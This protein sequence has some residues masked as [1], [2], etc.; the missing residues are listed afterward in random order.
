[1]VTRV[2]FFY[3]MARLESKTVT[4]EWSQSRFYKISKDLI[5]KPSLFVNK[6]MSFSASVIIN[7]GANCLVFLCLLVVLCYILRTISPHLTRR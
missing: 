5:D 1:M 4:R 7:I 3:R 2:T 6:E